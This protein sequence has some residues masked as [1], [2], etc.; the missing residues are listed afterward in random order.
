MK[1]IFMGTPDFAVPVLENLIAHHYDIQAV[2]TQPDRPVG[3]KRELKPTPVKEVALKHNLPV[4]QPEKLSGSAEMEE[5]MTLQPDLIITAA[6]GQFLPQR[7]LDI[8]I[9]GCLNVHGSLLPKYRGGAPIQYAILSG[10]DKTGI[11]IME[12]V[13]KMDAG[14][15]VKQAEVPIAKQDDAGT[16]FDKLS[17]LG[18]DLLIETIPDYVAGKI[19][20]IPQDE[21]QVSYS[22]NI[23][24]ADEQINW[25]KTAEQIDC[26]VRALRPW[27]IAHTLLGDKR[28][29]LWQ[30]T[31][32]AEETN[33]APG[34]IVKKSKKEL[35]IACG[36][37]TVLA[38][39][40]VQPA[41]K[42][43]M[44]ITSFLNG[45]GKDLQVGDQ[46]NG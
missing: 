37:K 16:I 7:L 17:Q 41:G 40:E 35:W 5:I 38:L 31:P 3:R 1:V 9:Y 46:L 15:I 12:M 18:A 11:T 10:D 24:R 8:P 20:P 44:D 25:T 42:S 21:S 34:T 27:P 30:V 6:F 43:K 2:V 23:S 4:L 29:K 36:K 13:K 26:Q 14:D 45:L 28:L 22:P 33:E 19:Q 32:L 39:N